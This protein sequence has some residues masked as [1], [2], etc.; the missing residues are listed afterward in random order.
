MLY[1]PKVICNTHYVSSE[2]IVLIYMNV[3]VNTGLLLDFCSFAYVLHDIG[4]VTLT[5]YVVAKIRKPYI[6]AYLHHIQDTY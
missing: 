5:I 3:K 2:F 4:I 6:F 1:L